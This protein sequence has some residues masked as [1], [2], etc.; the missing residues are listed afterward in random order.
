MSP[1]ASYLASFLGENEFS[2]AT[3]FL[4]L[5]VHFCLMVFPLLFILGFL[6]R[7]IKADIQ[8]RI[9]PNRSGLLGFWQG[10]ADFFKRFFQ[11]QVFSPLKESWPHK[12][13]VIFSL[14]ALA[15]ATTCVP[16]ASL[17]VVS[18]TQISLLIIFL[19]LISV[20]VFLFWASYVVAS[21][22]SQL[23]SFRIFNTFGAYI[24]PLSIG[25]LPVV[26]A[27]GSLNV[28]DIVKSQGG[29]PWNWNLF[30]D[31]GAFL[32]GFALFS[33]LLIWQSRLP[34]DY[35]SA[36]SELQQGYRAEYSGT[37]GFY[38]ELIDHLSF[39]I[40]CSLL[41]SLYLGGWQTPFNLASFGRAASLVEWF[42][43]VTK[44]FFL[45]FLSIWLRWSLPRATIEQIFVFSWDYIVPI[46]L[47]GV[48]VSLGWTGFVGKSFAQLIF[49]V[50]GGWS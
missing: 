38:L 40:V 50:W 28:F 3:L 43:F 7:K 10:V 31:P 13:G 19:A 12:I 46:G 23:S 49:G 30:H 32:G 8:M 11:E 44:F 24:L 45:S 6:D 41:V 22:W 34:F 5:V 18:D 35:E 21:P 26:L 2:I 29:M 48:F 39:F 25:L 36:A 42:F 47:F 27:A 9:G 4:A 37:R 1:L 20:K 17:W 14:G 16:F 33:S 15:V